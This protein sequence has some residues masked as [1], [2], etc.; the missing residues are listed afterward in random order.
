MPSR[1]VFQ[2]P[3]PLA[4]RQDFVRIYPLFWLVVWSIYIAEDW[5][6]I[7]IR[8][9]ASTNILFWIAMHVPDAIW[10]I[11]VVKL[12]LPGTM[13][14]K[15]IPWYSALI[16]LLLALMT[17]LFID[18][19]FLQ[20]IKKSIGI[21]DPNT[22]DT[23]SVA[24]LSRTLFNIGAFVAVAHLRAW[25]QDSKVLNR[26][27]LRDQTIRYRLDHHTLLNIIKQIHSRAEQ[28]ND[29][30]T[31]HL[32]H[33]VHLTRYIVYFSKR[34]LVPLGEEVAMLRR[35]V[36]LLRNVAPGKM[37]TDLRFP[38]IEDCRGSVPPML[39]LPLVENAFKHGANK[40]TKTCRIRINMKI[41]AKNELVFKCRNDRPD[42]A[43]ISE[44]VD[45]FQ[46]EGLALVRKQLAHRKHDL[47]IEDIP[48]SNYFQVT[49]T[50]QL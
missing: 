30:V 7:S 3:L 25:Y 23:L 46:G 18:F 22:F 32:Y 45:Y 12:V 43:D 19:A 47:H 39:F 24:N 50:L 41:T 21:Q 11:V 13:G 36:A 44:V 17:I 5:H 33:L 42:S 6:W 29:I 4:P 49:L 9:A 8:H 35:F 26:E 27:A 2:T 34:D 28:N 14:N 20:E 15:K 31:E 10:A 37:T 40:M 1:T 48:G 16:L 38:N